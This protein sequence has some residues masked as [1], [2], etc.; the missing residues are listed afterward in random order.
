M[1]T[2]SL[3]RK[4][5]AVLVVER[6][7]PV[8]AFW[9]KLAVLPTVEVPDQ[10]AGD[11]RLAF[12]ILAAEGI[13]VMYQTAAS[14]RADLVQ[15]ASVKEAFAAGPQQVTLYVE[16]SQLEDVAARLAGERLVMP[17]RTTFYGSTELAYTDPAGNIVVFSQHQEAAPAQA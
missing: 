14:V 6:I 9:K 5:T 8:L 7:E 17:R 13:E 10:A 16:V 12:A 2:V 15:S 4:S 1:A 11:G 3:L